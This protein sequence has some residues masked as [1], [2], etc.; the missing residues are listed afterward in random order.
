MRRA[1]AIWLGVL[2]SLVLA[3][4]V[5]AKQPIIEFIPINDIGV[6]D[7][8]LS[9]ACGVD[10]YA[11]VTGH[12]IARS[13]TDANGDEVREV[14]NYGIDITVYS[15]YGSLRL[16]DTGVDRI[17]FNADGTLTQVIIGNAQSVQ[18]RGEGRV[19][20]DVGRTTLLITFPED[21]SEEPMFELLGQSGQHTDADQA[22]FICAALAP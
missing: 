21:P 13:F 9:A 19:Y 20:S 17:T 10:V 8:G 6:Y 15:E 1:L 7:P 18:L 4:P 5:A 14:N 11:D 2:A 12:I 22:D 16:H 3:M